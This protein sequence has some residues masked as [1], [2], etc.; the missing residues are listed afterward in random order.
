MFLNL[1]PGIK[2]LIREGFD[3]SFIVPFSWCV[4]ALTLPI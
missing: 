3:S 2:Y 4:V 1:L